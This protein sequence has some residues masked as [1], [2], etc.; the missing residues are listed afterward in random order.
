MR[1]QFFN[2]FSKETLKFL[3]E[4]HWKNSRDWFERNR[5]SYNKYLL[6]PFRALAVDLGRT[7][8][9]IDSRLEVRPAVNKTISRI[10]RDTRFSKDKSLF[11]DRMWLGFKRRVEDWKD[12]PAF[13]FELTPDAYR[14]GMGYYSASR[15]TMD[16]LRERIDDNAKKFL[17]AI[18]F[19]GKQDRFV[20]GGEK[21]KRLFRSDHTDEIQ[22]WYQRK[23][24]Y[25]VCERGIDRTLFSSKLVEVVTDDYLL[26]EP[27]YRYLTELHNY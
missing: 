24:F 12:S 6:N 15:S 2:G 20:L 23:S 22:E 11:K 16:R 10:H 14:Y 17:K 13:F 4:V 5:D 25:L 21:Y 9:S 7:V 3:H 8:S 27:L 19:Y 18:A 1:E 26:L